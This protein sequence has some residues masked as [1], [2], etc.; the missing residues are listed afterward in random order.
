MSDKIKELK[1]DWLDCLLAM[2]NLQRKIQEIQKEILQI[3][4]EEKKN[5]GVKAKGE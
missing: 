4:E 3:Q 5:K 1:A 2:E